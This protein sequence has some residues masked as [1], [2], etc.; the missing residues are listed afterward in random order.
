MRL[1]DAPNITV[2]SYWICKL[3]SYWDLAPTDIFAKVLCVKGDD[4]YFIRKNNYGYT[5]LPPCHMKAEEFLSY[6]MRL[7]DV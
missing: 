5:D 3:V 6:Y 2:G 7:E 1:I 4:I